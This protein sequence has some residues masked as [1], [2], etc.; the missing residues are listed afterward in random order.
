ELCSSGERPVAHG[1]FLDLPGLG[2][3]SHSLPAAAAEPPSRAAAVVLV[4]FHRPAQLA[5][6]PRAAD[7]LVEP[8]YCATL[9]DR[10]AIL[11]D[12]RRCR[13]PV[14]KLVVITC[15]DRTKP[16]RRLMGSSGAKIACWRRRA[17]RRAARPPCRVR[18]SRRRLR[19]SVLGA[20]ILLSSCAPAGILD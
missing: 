10:V 6:D 5:A 7:D 15:G 11:E 2:V 3:R 20:A 17:R 8:P 9:T 13:G 12:V 19:W 18:R 16:S 14:G 1:R 4:V